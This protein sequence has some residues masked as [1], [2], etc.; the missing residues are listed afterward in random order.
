MKLCAIQVPYGKDLKDTERSVEFLIN[1]LNT[2]DESLNLI[3]T[4]EYSNGPGELTPEEALPFY[5]AHTEKLV[6]AALDAAKRCHATVALSGCFKIGENYRN[7]TRVYNPDGTI[8]GDY[9]KQQLVLREPAE[10]GVENT[11]T[12]KWKLPEV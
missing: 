10:H 1:E 2:C 8:A 7:T 6:E 3:L 9:Y 12:R 11:H 4:P 5:I